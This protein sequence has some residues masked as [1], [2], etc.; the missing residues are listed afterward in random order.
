MVQPGHEHVSLFDKQ[1]AFLSKHHDDPTCSSDDYWKNFHKRPYVYNKE[2]DALLMGTDHPD[3]FVAWKRGTTKDL[4]NFEWE[5][6][7]H[8]SYRDPTLPARYAVKQVEETVVTP[9]V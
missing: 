1:F 6:P 3:C 4:E 2:K 8:M 9:E 5:L 7:E